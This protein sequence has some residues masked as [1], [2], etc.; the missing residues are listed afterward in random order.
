MTGKQLQRAAIQVCHARGFIV[1]HF[2]AAQVRQGVFVT[3]IKA[4]GKGFPDMIVAGHGRVFAIEVKGTNDYVKPEQREWL[5]RLEAGGV[6]TLVL[7]P[8]KWRAGALDELLRG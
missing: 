3:P 2:T 8:S 1:A 5:N 7:T 6:K 4:D